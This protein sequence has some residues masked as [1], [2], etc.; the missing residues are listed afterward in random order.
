LIAGRWDP[1]QDLLD[2]ADDVTE[3]ATGLA[4]MGL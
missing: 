3:V 4:Y 1:L 2:G